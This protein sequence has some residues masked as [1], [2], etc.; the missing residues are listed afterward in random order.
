MHWV[1]ALP[2]V[3][4]SCTDFNE[5]VFALGFAGKNEN[6]AF[7]ARELRRA[8]LCRPDELPDD[9]V[10]L[11]CRVIFQLEGDR[12]IHASLLVHPHNLLCPTTEL[13]ALSPIGTALLGLRAGDLMPFFAAGERR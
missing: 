5:L 3:T 1:S 8:A 13:S 10:A 12:R 4:M 7:L 9:V 11:N 2:P 6:A